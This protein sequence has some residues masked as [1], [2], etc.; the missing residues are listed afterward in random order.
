MRLG[1]YRPVTF[2]FRDKDGNAG[3]QFTEQLRLVWNQ[4]AEGALGVVRALIVGDA[5]SRP[6]LVARHCH[7]GR[8]NMQ[9][10]RMH[11]GHFQM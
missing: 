4:C 7:N 3:N 5:V 6:N 1:D 8:G 9:I 2:R 10:I 11:V